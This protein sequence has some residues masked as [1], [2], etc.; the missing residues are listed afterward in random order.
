MESCEFFMYF[1]DQTLV[2]SVIGK[3][4]FPYGWFPFHF[5]DVFFSRAEGS[6]YFL[7]SLVISSVIFGLFRIM[8]FNF[9]IFGDIYRYLSANNFSFNSTL[10][11]GYSL[12]DFCSLKFIEPC[13]MGQNMVHPE[14]CSLHTCILILE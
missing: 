7:I 14:K 9:P 10:T 1:G 6:A 13:F 4:I 11:Q 12:C 8:F 2:C 3:Y 5:V